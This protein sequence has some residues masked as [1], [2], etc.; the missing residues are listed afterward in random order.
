MVGKS[1]VLKGLAGALVLLVSAIA[2]MQG[3]V[4]RNLEEI[5]ESKVFKVGVIPYDVDIIKKPG[6]D[7]YEGVFIE[8]IEAVCEAMQVKCEYQE[9][10]WQSFVGAIQARQIDLSIATTYATIPR[11]MAVNFSRPIYFLGYKAVARKDDARFSSVEDLNNK[12]VRVA[13]CQGCG[14]MDWVQ[15]VAPEANLRVVPTEEGAML[16]VVTG[17][18]DIAVGASAAA[19]HALSTQPSLA[20]ALGD[21]IYSKNQVA[22]AMNKSDTDLKF[23]VDVAIGQL[24]ASGKLKELAD[25]YNAPWKDT[26]SE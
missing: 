23:F 2:P 18:A 13:V 16:E 4:A 22:W 7:T 26:I 10:T 11:A 21:R 15:K 17:Q 1:L 19:D 25:K 20:P 14:Q 9:Y 5:A 3:A 8:A 12:Q 24:I 6:S